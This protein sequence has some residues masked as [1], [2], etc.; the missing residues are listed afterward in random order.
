MK[1]YNATHVAFLDGLKYIKSLNQ[2]TSDESSAFTSR[3]HLNVMRI[4]PLDRQT[5]INTVFHLLSNSLFRNTEDSP[6][7]YIKEII[8][9]LRQIDYNNELNIVKNII[10]IKRISKMEPAPDENSHVLALRAVFNSSTSTTFASIVA[11]LNKE[12][13]IQQVLDELASQ[14]QISHGQN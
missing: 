10:E 13:Q 7:R 1:L 3:A 14:K 5:N 2:S 6:P 4:D 8:S 11:N 9:I 12:P